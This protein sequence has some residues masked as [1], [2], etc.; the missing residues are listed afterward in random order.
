MVLCWQPGLSTSLVSSRGRTPSPGL[1]K[2][3]DKI[4]SSNWRIW[5]WFLIESISWMAVVPPDLLGNGVMSYATGGTLRSAIDGG[6]NN[7]EFQEADTWDRSQ[8]L[9]VLALDF[10]PPPPGL[11]AIQVAIQVCCWEPWDLPS[12]RY[13]DNPSSS[14]FAQ[15][16]WGLRQLW[17]EVR[18][19]LQPQAYTLSV[20]L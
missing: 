6:S 18:R 12:W 1:E 7:F 15:S 4:F 20:G 2:M 16:P 17:P 13:P 3:H 9:L 19:M 10:P 14:D 11:G 8:G 5:N